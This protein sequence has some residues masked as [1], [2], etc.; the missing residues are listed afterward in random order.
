MHMRPVIAFYAPPTSRRKQPLL[1]MRFGCGVGLHGVREYV[2]KRPNIE[3][4][5]SEILYWL[6]SIRR[7]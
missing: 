1:T 7:M 4:E 5:I 2:R 6:L 3:G